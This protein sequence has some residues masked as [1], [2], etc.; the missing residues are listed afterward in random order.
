MALAALIGTYETSS[1][2]SLRALVLNEAYLASFGG[3]EVPAHVWNA[4]QRFGAWIEPALNS[5]S[6]RPL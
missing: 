6:I 3:L 5:P 1:D 2:G 4:L